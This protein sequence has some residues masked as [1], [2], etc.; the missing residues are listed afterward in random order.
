M[1]KDTTAMTPEATSIWIL[2]GGQV[3]TDLKS[4]LRAAPSDTIEDICLMNVVEPGNLYSV[5]RL[6]C[7]LRKYYSSDDSR[8]L[9]FH[10]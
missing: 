2:V 9:G 10:I 4:K 7:A 1:L 5:D 3:W 6:I 8:F